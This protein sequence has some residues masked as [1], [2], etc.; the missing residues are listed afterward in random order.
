MFGIGGTEAVVL[1]II[2]MIVLGPERLPRFAADAARFLRDLRAMADRARSDVT[3]EL[4]PEFEDIDVRD[5][6]PR[7]FVSRHLLGDDEEAQA[8]KRRGAAAQRKKSPPSASSPPV[9]LGKSE[10]PQAP[11]PFDDDAT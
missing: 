6:D 2:A 11:P 9:D 1:L 3:R 10:A 5:L 7:R 8:T 4:G